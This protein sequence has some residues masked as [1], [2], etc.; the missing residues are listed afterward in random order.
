MHD[1][2]HDFLL[3]LAAPGSGKVFIFPTLA[4][5]RTS[6]KS[7]L[8]MA[9]KCIME[10]AK[11]RG[12]VVH[13]RAG[14]AGRTVNTLSFHSFRP[15]VNRRRLRQLG[16]R[17]DRDREQQQLP[18]QLRRRRWQR[19]YADGVTVACAP[20]SRSRSPRSPRN[21]RSDACCQLSRAN[22]WCRLPAFTGQM[23]RIATAPAPVSWRTIGF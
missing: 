22:K 17:R 12:E 23:T 16:R 10:R 7:G 18:S 5:K 4:G 2:L 3:E 20:K 21:P 11:V 19:S 8:S 1:S 6:G 15:T 13:E 9:F 14:D